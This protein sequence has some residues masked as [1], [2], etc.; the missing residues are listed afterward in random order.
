MTSYSKNRS[1]I[2]EVSYAGSLFFIESSITNSLI[3]N[4]FVLLNHCEA[5]LIFFIYSNIYNI[6]AFELHKLL[7][8]TLFGYVGVHTFLTPFVV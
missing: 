7:S 3:T 1:M 8:P 5:K 2:Q 4:L 6:F